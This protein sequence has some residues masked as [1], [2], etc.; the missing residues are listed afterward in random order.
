M[1][2]FVAFIK[3]LM[4]NVDI[5]RK[6][7]NANKIT[8]AIPFFGNN[9]WDDWLLHGGELPPFKFEQMELDLPK[10]FDNEQL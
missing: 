8:K 5:M 9:E 4:Y 10:G 6:N 3:Q 1:H 2:F 7:R